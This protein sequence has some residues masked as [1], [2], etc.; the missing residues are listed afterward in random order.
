MQKILLIIALFF[1]AF[2][3]IAQSRRLDSPASGDMLAKEFSKEENLVPIVV[4][5]YSYFDLN[6]K[7]PIFYTL[8]HHSTDSNLFLIKGEHLASYSMK[9]LKNGKV[10][11]MFKRKALRLPQDYATTFAD[12]KFSLDSLR[13]GGKIGRIIR[14]RSEPAWLQNDMTPLTKKGTLC[15]LFARWILKVSQ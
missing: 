9:L 12:S 8:F 14:F 15:Y 13:N 10:Q 11:P 6:V 1:S 2:H 3:L 5:D 7:I 4:I